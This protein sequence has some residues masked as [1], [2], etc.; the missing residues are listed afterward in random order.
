V[1]P[2]FRF[3]VE[4]RL[5]IQEAYDSYQERSEGLGERFLAALDE[6]LEVVAANPRAFPTVHADVRRALLHRF[7]YSVL[8]RSEGELIIVLGCFH[9]RRDPR[10]QRERG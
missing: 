8:Y 6:L 3:G 9:G 5:D 7:P 1:K 4:A 10:R 2:A